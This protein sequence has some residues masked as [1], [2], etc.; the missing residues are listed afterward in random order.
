MP[1]CAS[2]FHA[3]ALVS[4]PLPPSQMLV[5]SARTFGYDLQLLVLNHSK[6]NFVST[7]VGATLPFLRSRCKTSVVLVLDAYDV[8]F[9]MP[10]SEALRRFY[11]ANSSVLWSVERMY[12]GQDEFDKPFYDAERMVNNSL[13]E[14]RG[15]TYGF[16]NSGGYMGYAGTLAALI[17]VAL[18][19]RPG[20]HGWRNK[21]CGEAHGRHCADQWIFGHTIAHTW[22]RFNVSFDYSRRLFYTATSHDWSYSYATM[23]IEESSPCIVHMP[24]IQAPR[25][26]ATLR[27]LYA[28]HVLRQPPPEA[29][30]SVC[31]ARADRCKLLSIGLNEALKTLEHFAQPAVALSRLDA[32]TT[33]RES[34]RMVE[35]RPALAVHAALD[36]RA[37]LADAVG[38]AH[39]SGEVAQGQVA[40]IRR[41]NWREVANVSCMGYSPSPGPSTASRTP[42]TRVSTCPPLCPPLSTSARKT[43]EHARDLLN[44]TVWEGVHR[45]L[46][47]GVA[48]VRQRGVPD[49][50]RTSTPKAR[51][52]CARAVARTA[53]FESSPWC[54]EPNS[55]VRTTWVSC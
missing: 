31:R 27:A 4:E 40:L 54:Y 2:E 52:A 1:P 45:C 17:E 36:S 39:A 44:D 15:K 5:H 33:S 47:H 42:T 22:N 49:V 16:L 50:M 9:R 24:F 41:S 25:V 34:S 8:F 53:L 29:D 48:E 23:R 32:P 46:R 3:V 35:L 20:A 38:S 7:R 12:S 19:V 18:T 13:G 6:D 14:A 43:C 10:A 37:R 55:G 26:N 28:T 21:T 11:A 51:F 30:L